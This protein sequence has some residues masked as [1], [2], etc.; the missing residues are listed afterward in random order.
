MIR[1]QQ[2]AIVLTSNLAQVIPPRSPPS[3]STGRSM[4]D[5]TMGIMMAVS[6]PQNY[7]GGMSCSAV[8]DGIR[9]SATQ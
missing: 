4:A 2:E 7:R 6:I 3:G 9:I 5:G 8:S 1:Q